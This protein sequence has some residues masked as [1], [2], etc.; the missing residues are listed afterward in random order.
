MSATGRRLIAVFLM[1]AFLLAASRPAR[2]DTLQTDADEI[3]IAIV[4]VAV[5]VGV[6]IFFIVRST[7]GHHHSITGCAVSG[8]DGLRLEAE[9]DGRAYLLAGKTSSIK[10]GDR[11]RVSGEKR[12]DAAKNALFV[13]ESLPKDL[14][15]CR[16]TP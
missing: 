3:G 2:A 16:A 10:A 12:K 13:V 8:P 4:A 7:H 15:A 6:G 14:G 1:C 5:A 11:V 9:G